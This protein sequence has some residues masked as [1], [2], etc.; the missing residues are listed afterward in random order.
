MRRGKPPTVHTV[1]GAP[2]TVKQAARQLGVPETNLEAWR[3]YHRDRNGAKASLEAAYDHYAEKGYRPRRPR[4]CVRGQS[5]TV[6][7]VAEQ[8]KI[9]RHT[10]RTAMYRHKCGLEEDLARCE[11]AREDR[12]V[13]R[14]L[15][16]IY[17]EG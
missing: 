15:A 10:L 12:A 11:R 13:K 1:H 8:Y 2:M 5:M 9:P 3:T 7:Q 17:G 16:I 14:I 6:K 4:Q